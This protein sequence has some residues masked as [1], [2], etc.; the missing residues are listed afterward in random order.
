MG[1]GWPGCSE[2]LNHQVLPPAPDLLGE[3]SGPSGS[4]ILNFLQ[5]LI[6]IILDLILAE[7]QTQNTE[8]TFSSGLVVGG[9][10]HFRTEARQAGRVKAG[11]G[12]LPWVG[13]G[14]SGSSPGFVPGPE[15]DPAPRGEVLAQG[16]DF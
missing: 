9:S 8:M 1:E 12:K 16:R 10:W 5:L 11:R 13:P 2:L 7:E 14:S 15:Q 3:K 4:F 6:P